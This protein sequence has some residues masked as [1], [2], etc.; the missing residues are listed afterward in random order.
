MSRHF[1]A[2]YPRAPWQIMC[3]DEFTLDYKDNLKCTCVECGQII[4]YVS[5]QAGRI[6]TCPKC[7]KKSRFPGG[8]D[9]EPKTESSSTSSK[10]K[11]DPLLIPGDKLPPLPRSTTPIT[12]SGEPSKRRCPECDC[13]LTP[14]D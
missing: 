4:G 9:P 12:K 2:R 10:A 8:P 7:G 3:S 14:K 11:K 13:P 5:V 6:C 1:S